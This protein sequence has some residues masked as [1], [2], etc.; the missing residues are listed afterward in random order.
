MTIPP[1]GWTDGDYSAPSSPPPGLRRTGLFVGLAVLAAAA[2]VATVAVVAVRS[3]GPDKSE[4]QTPTQTMSIA[5]QDAAFY[6]WVN[7]HPWSESGESQE[8]WTSL[9]SSMCGAMDRGAE[10]SDVATILIDE[11]SDFTLSDAHDFVAKS[12]EI[13]CPE[14]SSRVPA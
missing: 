11:L 14:Y 4:A 3:S 9:A 7:R 13:Y 10:Y 8:D 6:R 2:I 12:V 1:P 5:D